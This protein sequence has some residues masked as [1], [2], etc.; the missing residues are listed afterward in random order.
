FR[1][2]PSSIGG[3]GQRDTSEFVIDGGT[4][5]MRLQVGRMAEG[6]PKSVGSAV[7]RDAAKIDKQIRELC[8]PIP[9]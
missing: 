5:D 1:P 6:L 8:R 3:A 7:G 4:Q 2:S 9:R